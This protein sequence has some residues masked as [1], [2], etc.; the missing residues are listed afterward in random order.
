MQ[1]RQK[2]TGN[3]NARENERKKIGKILLSQKIVK[4]FPT[5]DE[6]FSEKGQL[7]I[8]NEKVQNGLRGVFFFC[9]FSFQD[10]PQNW[11]YVISP[12]FLFGI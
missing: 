6:S 12:T 7:K 10:R 1:S 11:P 8:A 9:D 4:I 2:M 3:K 5:C